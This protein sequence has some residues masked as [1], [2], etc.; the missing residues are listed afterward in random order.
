[1]MT[2][3]TP[4][5]AAE[6][7]GIDRIL[8][9]WLDDLFL[10]AQCLKKERME[11]KRAL[12][13]LF[14]I[15]FIDLV[16]FGIIIPLLPFYA[17]RYGAEPYLVT[18]LMAIYSFF[19]FLFAPLWGRLSDRWGRR[20][21]LILTLGGLAAAYVGFAF[22]GALWVLFAVRAL[23]GAM[24][25]NIA[26]AQAYIADVTTREKRAQGMGLIGAAF[27]LGFTVGPAIGGLLAGSDPAQLNVQLPALTAAVLSL[28]AAV[29]AV[30][31]LPES[32][33]AEQ[34]AQPAGRTGRLTQLTM[35][36]RQPQVGLLIGLFFL[37]T[38][39]FSGMESTFALWSERQFG[40]GP[41]QNG[42]VFAFTGVLGAIIQGGL[43]GRL[44]ARF[45][46]HNLLKQGAGALVV[47]FAA[48]PLATHFGALLVA[49]GVMAYGLS[50]LTPSLNSL[51]SKNAPQSSQ[52][53][54]FGLTQSASSLARILGPIWA[55]VLFSAL[56]RAWPFYSGALLMS[57]LLF[58]SVR[59]L[60]LT[61]HRQEAS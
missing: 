37:Q 38:F 35:A 5:T 42:Y 28:L 1:M 54:T 41:Q 14:F 56:G 32:L 13:I 61:P 48:M 33:S 30:V 34:R 12:G 36:L 31:A 20:P 60:P 57:V 25:G 29:F 17:E 19:Q 52:G 23:A 43:I 39:A 3:R 6:A 9:R 59:V 10:Q 49:V 21:I 44:S 11:N 26:T 4:T 47:G 45:G 46:E 24:A 8:S 53:Q 2:S 16:G 58:F 55:G 18:L 40:W 51:I 7:L 22:A 15:V 50:V 27:G